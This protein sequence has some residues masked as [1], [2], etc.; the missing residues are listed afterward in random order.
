MLELDL[1]RRYRKGT[2]FELKRNIIEL[3]V[4]EISEQ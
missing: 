1:H 2:I 4:K 3:N